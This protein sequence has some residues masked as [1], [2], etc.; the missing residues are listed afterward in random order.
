M[1]CNI[2]G[3][4]QLSASCGG[5][6][7]VVNGDPYCFASIASRSDGHDDVSIAKRDE[8]S[9]DTSDEDLGVEGLIARD[10]ASDR[11][12]YDLVNGIGDGS[13]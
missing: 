6:C 3:N 9:S 8:E 5:P 12:W 11:A 10:D 7:R 13:V 4:W 2:S 1:I